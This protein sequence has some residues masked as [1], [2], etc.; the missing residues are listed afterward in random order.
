MCC[1]YEESKRAAAREVV[2]IRKDWVQQREAIDA[3]A[4]ERG[5]G[6]S[7]MA[8]AKEISDK[9][10]HYIENDIDRLMR[11]VGGGGGGPAGVGAGG[12]AA[13]A[14]AFPLAAPTATRLAELEARG[15]G[16]G[17]G[18]D[19][20]SMSE[21][22]AG[23]GGG[24]RGRSSKAFSSSLPSHLDGT[25]A[26]PGCLA[27]SASS[28][29]GGGGGA[30]SSSTRIMA[31]WSKMRSVEAGISAAL[32]QSR[33]NSVDVAARVGGK[34]G[35]GGG[36]GGSGAMLSSTADV[37]Q[38]VPRSSA[39]ATTLPSAKGGGSAEQQAG[40]R[41]R[42]W[43]PAPIESSRGTADTR[44]RKAARSVLQ[45]IDLECYK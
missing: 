43:R 23:E 36:V 39:A 44:L 41:G 30:S 6:G 24:R 45:G 19:A 21:T 29:G 27:A 13:A 25:A 40:Q 26:Q 8:R 7:L 37:G 3:K 17:G 16:G 12:G 10:S 35:G 15:G 9:I 33:K 38:W 34:V 22:R 14:S 42:T 31:P 2:G 20:S 32:D 18:E 1:R 11:L 4:A 5:P 28:I